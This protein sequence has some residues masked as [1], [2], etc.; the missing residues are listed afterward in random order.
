MASKEKR[1]ARE[2]AALDRIERD[3]DRADAVEAEL[4]SESDLACLLADLWSKNQF[5][6]KTSG[7]LPI[8]LCDGMDRLARLTGE[9]PKRRVR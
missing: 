2:D 3:M 7:A 8:S 1:K 4:L 5:R 9:S 6:L